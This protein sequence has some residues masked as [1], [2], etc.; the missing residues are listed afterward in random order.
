M[1]PIGNGNEDIEMVPVEN[2][3]RFRKSVTKNSEQLNQLE[4]KSDKKKAKE[5]QLKLEVSSVKEP[6]NKKGDTIS[7]FES[8]PFKGS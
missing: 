5:L 3:F 6:R 1:L 2:Q 4:T 7:E 8:N